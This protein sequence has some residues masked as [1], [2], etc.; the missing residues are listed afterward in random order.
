MNKSQRAA[1]EICNAN[2]V[3]QGMYLSD[4]SDAEAA[5]V[6]TVVGR[7]VTSSTGVDWWPRGTV[8]RAI[9]VLSR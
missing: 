1:V 7:P 9:D 4:L 5:L 6:T 2:L 3:G 8:E